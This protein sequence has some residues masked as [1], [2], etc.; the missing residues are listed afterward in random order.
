MQTDHTHSHPR[1]TWRR[2]TEAGAGAGGS[3]ERA[4][5]SPAW[6]WRGVGPGMRV[7][8]IEMTCGGET[9]EFSS[10][11]GWEG[12]VAKIEDLNLVCRP[13]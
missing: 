2:S 9:A 10:K 8:T 13:E 3:G 4:P 7:S 11:R 1:H 6:D 5:L 12:I